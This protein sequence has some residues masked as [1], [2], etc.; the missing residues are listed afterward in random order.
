[1]TPLEDV[2]LEEDSESVPSSLS[3]QSEETVL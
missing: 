2:F 1:M 3:N